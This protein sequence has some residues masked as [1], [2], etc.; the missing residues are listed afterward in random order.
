MTNL[1]QSFLYEMHANK[2][3][4]FEGKKSEIESFLGGEGFVCAIAGCIEDSRRK[5]RRYRRHRNEKVPMASANKR[6][7]NGC[8]ERRND[9]EVKR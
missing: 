8:A 3:Q 7:K 4:N 6:K 9:L 1:I 2:E 5:R